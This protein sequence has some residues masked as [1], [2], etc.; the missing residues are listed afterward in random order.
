V[1][2][3]N[4]DLNKL[5][6]F[7]AIAEAGGVT[8]AARR[9]SVT[10]SAVSHSLA[11]L[12]TSL[13]VRLFHRVGRRLVPTSEGA[14][15]RRAVAETRDRLESAL[16]EALGAGQEVRGPIR[17]GLFLG[18]SRFR[19]AAVVAGFVRSH[20][21]ARVR[22][23]YGPQAWLADQLRAGRLDF[24]VSLR[25]ARDAA[26]HLRSEPLFEQSLVLAARQL[27]RRSS[28]PWAAVA[29][30]PIVDYYQSDPLI[31]RWT[32]RHYGGRRIPRE[33]IRVWAATTDLALELVLGGVGAA[34]LPDDVVE[35]FRR[36]GEL[37]VAPGRRGPLRD[38]VWLNELRDARRSRAH[39]VF[40]EALL[41]SLAG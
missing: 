41:G 10:R 28:P 23:A 4:V 34:V 5:L 26:T 15:L 25:S 22:V 37:V 13:G 36:R 20:P 6:G 17:I 24:S 19:L 16:D 35:P 31:D 1:E 3:N 12:E 29:G 30:L 2:L 21:R 18:F 7:L 27:P 39:A 14:A 32:Q 38:T 40:R 33:R 11:A 9:L 8:P